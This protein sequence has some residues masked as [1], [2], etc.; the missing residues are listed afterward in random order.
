MLRKWVWDA[1]AGT[2][3]S[4]PPTRWDPERTTSLGL[5]W[6][7][8]A[9]PVSGWGTSVTRRECPQERREPDGASREMAGRAP[10]VGPGRGGEALRCSHSLLNA[11]IEYLLGKPLGLRPQRVPWAGEAWAWRQA[12]APTPGCSSGDRQPSSLSGKQQSPASGSV[13]SG[14]RA[15]SPLFP[16][17][18]CALCGCHH[19]LINR[20]VVLSSWQSLWVRRAIPLS[21]SIIPALAT[22]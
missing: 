18:N 12:S 17:Q 9:L 15:P 16:R 3:P 2:S 19:S 7:R 20:P 14:T 4:A 21:G 13:S 22:C 5:A 10:E 11:L 8:A 1:V 6:P